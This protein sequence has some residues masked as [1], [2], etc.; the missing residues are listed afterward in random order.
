MVGPKGSTVVA[1]N[2]D[3]RVGGAYHGAMREAA[4][5]VMWAKFTYREI[6]PPERLVWVRSFSDEGGGLTRHPLAP[7]WPL[8]LLTIVTFE[9]EPGGETLTLRWSPLNATGDEQKTLDAAHDG[10]RQGWGG[11][12]ERLT[13]Y[14]STVK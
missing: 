6:V 14:L 12:F 4:G 1:S 2:M 7:T 3:L 10:M 8:E 5:R 13:A 9:E 11:S